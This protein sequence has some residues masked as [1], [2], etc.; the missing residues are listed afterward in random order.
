MIFQR[1][2]I[3]LTLWIVSTSAAAKEARMPVW[4]LTPKIVGVLK[5][6]QN[7]LVSTG[8]PLV[9]C[10]RLS[11]FRDPPSDVNTASYVFFDFKARS[12]EVCHAMPKENICR[13]R[14]CDGQRDGPNCG[15]QGMSS[16]DMNTYDMEEAVIELAA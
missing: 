9:L 3:R 6:T 7:L 12:L 14:L 16:G 8:D 13:G 5:G 10:A 1:N 2:H 4:L 11:N 15:C